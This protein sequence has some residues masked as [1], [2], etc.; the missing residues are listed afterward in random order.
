MT[1]AE[2][3]IRGL[4]AA[5]HLPAAH[6][7]R[8]LAIDARG[9][10]AMLAFARALKLRTGQIVEALDLLDEIAVR[11]R[12]EVAD[13][14][15]RPLLARLPGAIGSR[16]DRARDFVAELRRM[17]FPRLAE[18]TALLDAEIAALKLP[19]GIRVVLPPRLSS[20]ELTIR[21]KVSSASEL[22][23]ALATLT[24]KRE[25]IARIIRILAGKDEV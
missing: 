15:L 16:P 1:S 4:A 18:S 14:L 24:Q 5:R 23:R 7:E 9:R 13:I 20:D 11:D 21:L 12:A 6:L 17:R 2:V 8:W 10:D 3:E 25:G 19:S 22:D